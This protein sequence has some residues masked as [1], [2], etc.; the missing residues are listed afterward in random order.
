MSRFYG[1]DGTPPFT[2]LSITFI[3]MRFSKCSHT[4]D[5]GFVK[6]MSESFCENGI[7]KMNIQFCC[8]LCCCISVIFRK[9]ILLNIRRSLS[10]NVDFRP[11]FLFADVVFPWFVHADI[12][13]ETVALVA[14][15]NVA[16]SS[17]MLQ[18][19]P[20]Q[21]SVRYQNR[22]SLPFSDSFTRTVTHSWNWSVLEKPTIVPLLKNFPVF[23]GTRM[24]IIVFK[25][26]LHWSLSWARSVHS[27]PS[28]LSKIHLIMSWSSYWT[29]SFFFRANIL[30]TRH[31]QLQ[32][33]CDRLFSVKTATPSYC[34]TSL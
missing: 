15:N 9:K 7:F 16:A 20:H 26:A 13:I 34:R 10:V 5:V 8:H 28:K 12:I 6:L 17:Q 32:T 21:R 4:M 24:F 25:R 2:Y 23:Y 27:I 11:L 14:L 3:S 19:N 33:G 22:T 18:R 31:V 30:Y 29:L 1:R